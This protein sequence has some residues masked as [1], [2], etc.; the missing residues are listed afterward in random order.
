MSEL[1]NNLKGFLDQ[2]YEENR[3]I[4]CLELPILKILIKNDDWVSRRDILSQLK[5]YG[6]FKRGGLSFD[7]LWSQRFGKGEES[8]ILNQLVEHDGQKNGDQKNKYKIKDTIRDELKSFLDNY[9]V[10]IKSLVT[11]RLIYVGEHNKEFDSICKCLDL[12]IKN[13]NGKLIL[14]TSTGTEINL[15]KHKNNYRVI[16]NSEKETYESITLDNLYKFIF[17][18]WRGAPE[19]GRDDN[20]ITLFEAIKEYITNS[21]KYE[22]ENLGQSMSLDESESENN[23]SACNNNTL[24]QILYGPP[25]TGKTYNA[26][27]KALEII[28]NKTKKELEQEDR[29]ILNSRFDSYQKSGQIEF[30]TFHQS[31]G[32]EEFVEGIKPCG[33]NNDCT[34]ENSN[35]RYK[36]ED[37]IFKKLALLAKENYDNVSK[38]GIKE[39][40]KKEEYRFK[41]KKLK[42]LIETSID[43]VDKYVIGDTTTYIYEI[44]DD[45]FRYKGDKWGHNQRMKFDDLQKLYIHNIKSR[46]DIKSLEDISGLARQHASYYLKMI[47]ELNKIQV[48]NSTHLEV[49]NTLQNYVL[50]IDEINRG[51]ISKIFG[52]L[53]TL[54]EDS[55]RLDADEALEIVL[56]YSGRKFGVPKNLYIVGTMNTADRSIAQID[57]A[58]RRRFVFEEMM[59]K[60]YL[61]VDK[62]NEPLKIE[63]T[64]ID[65][66]KI[67]EAINERIEYIY[68]REHTIGHSYFMDLKDGCNTK[69]KLDEIFKVNIIP[70]LAEYFYGDWN[71]IKVVLNDFKLNGNSENI[72]NFI[73]VEESSKSKLEIKKE[74]SNNKIYKINKEF[75]KERYINIYAKKKSSK[76]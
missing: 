40:E 2:G 60:P 26:I 58:L 73:E 12:G 19:L 62:N 43:D 76:S 51:N 10:D 17:E 49:N 74:T 66:Q 7:H 6:E 63:S 64:E 57:T 67:L 24:N 15:I 56:P 30:I 70:L 54:I 14:K 36:V 75:A 65:V 33:L 27:N 50:I 4:V 39:L 68:D 32:Y 37:G 18:N 41:L 3:H 48:P 9:N 69:L 72:E 44:E 8:D 22:Q 31:Y 13:S 34:N 11:K 52:E 28:E 35:I 46:S 29:N 53:I 61:L 42:D 16:F 21:C 38:I 47:E 5:D 25:G 45:A 1:I 55:K 20:R 59:P 71:D 23:A